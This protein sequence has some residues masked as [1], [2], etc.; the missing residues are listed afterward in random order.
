MAV[1][2]PRLAGVKLR[3]ARPEDA[4]ACGRI[5][6]EAFRSI[7]ERHNFPPDFPSA[8]VGEG[9]V[10]HL[11]S[12][13]GF[14]G[15]VAELD[16]RVAGSN[17]LDERS[18]IAGVGPITIDPGVQD[19]GVGRLLMRDVLDR[20]AGRGVAGVRLLQS[21]YHTR[22]LSLYTKLGFEVRELCACMQGPPV[23]VTVPG[24]AVR[25]AREP[26]LE[27]CNRI[28]RL[29]HG[30]DRDGE[31]RDGIR[32]G[33]AVVVEHDGR[34][35]GYASTMAFFGHAAG[36]TAEDL[37]ALIGAA[38]EFGGPGILVPTRSPLFRWCLERGLRVVQPLTLMSM[39]LYNEPAG[40]YLPSILY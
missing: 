23:G 38:P 9:L 13:P 29:V 24:Y 39:G 4:P 27:S 17:F 30:H 40:A 21:T 33:T 19:R 22:S 28:C 6:Y 34:V 1:Q 12:H 8:D 20:A 11:V 32:E 36:E 26:D 3:T 15:V 25:P 7:A 14:Y 16:G 35:T 10:A 5:C 18:A 37:K 31:V 2:E